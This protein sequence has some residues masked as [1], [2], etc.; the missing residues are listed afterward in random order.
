[1]FR[2]IIVFTCNGRY[3]NGENHVFE[4]VL[5][6]IERK[7]GQ[8]MK[9]G[10]IRQMITTIVGV[11]LCGVQIMGCYPLVPAYFA[12]LYLEEVKG[13][14]LAG[15][16]YIGML[17]FM[18]L[19]AAVKYAVA[20]LVI[21]AMIK[22]VRWANEGC[23]AYIAGILSAVT[24][25]ILSFSGGLLQWKAQPKMWAMIFEGIFIF[26]AV[27]LINRLLHEFF[28]WK[29]EIKET[30]QVV[31]E[32][33][34]EERLRGYAESFQGLSQVFQSMS[35]K[36]NNFSP[37]ELGRIQNEL[38]GKVCA[39]CDSCALCWERDGTP[40]YG[41]LSKIITSVINVGEVQK[42][43]QQELKEYCK[44]SSD[45][46]EEAV[47]VFEKA[48]LNRAWYN[49]LLENRQTIAEQLDAMAYIMQD[50]AKEEEVLDKVEKRK[51][52]EIRYRA[53]E[54]GIVIDEIHLRMG[55]EGHLKLEAKLHSKRGGCI[56]I[57]TFQKIVQHVLEK[58][59]RVQEECKSFITKEV[60]EFRLFEDTKFRSV[61]GISRLKKDGAQISGDNFSFLEMENG[62][63]MLGLSDGMGS[64]TTAC[65]ESE[66][67]LDLV[68]RFMEAG[69]SVETAIRMMNS[70]MVMKGDSDLFSTVDVCNIDLYSGNAEF[71]K[72][73]A[74]ASF[75]KR[76]KEVTCYSADSLP[77]GVGTN[78][79]I[80]RKQ[81][82]LKNGDFVVMVT[83]GVLEYLHVPKPEET[84]REIIESIDTSH[85]GI[86]VKKMMER[87]LLFTGG[88]VQDDMT[89][90]ATCIWEK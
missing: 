5:A 44:R 47:R 22:L 36:K 55:V 45:M 8:D 6:K 34:N 37:E 86:L 26:G 49:R 14:W 80:E 82:S 59:L 10:K 32:K 42:E 19:T 84:M 27:M 61:Q 81:T 38:T 40:L 11:L 87:I 69:F 90:L 17:Y 64:G 31:V 30:E 76:G 66:M 12:A 2:I 29:W 58:E 74:A 52:A 41:I 13:I 18:P 50:C 53:K 51:M 46:I 75:I 71:Y 24:T 78:P 3:E 16:M 70:A 23:P 25:M 68:E 65:K 85:P 28:T 56:S 7:E 63:L 77:V 89:I 48:K 79:E 39:N 21:A 43:N 20:V 60:V 9:Q 1:M 62:K 88:K 35:V 73:G 83:D 72:I 4:K 33:R 15:A 54:Y 67:V 57:K